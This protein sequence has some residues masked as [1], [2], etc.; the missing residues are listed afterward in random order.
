MSQQYISHKHMPKLYTSHF[1]LYGLPFRTCSISSGKIFIH[2]TSVTIPTKH[3][4][5]MQNQAIYNCNISRIYAKVC[6][7]KK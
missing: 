2:T 5:L 1:L 4:L 3:G 6:V 7:F